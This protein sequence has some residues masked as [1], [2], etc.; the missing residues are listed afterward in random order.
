MADA[1]GP[2]DLQAIR[3]AMR[4]KLTLALDGTDIDLETDVAWQNRKFVKPESRS[5]LWAE[6]ILETIDE[7]Q[8]SWSMAQWLGYYTWSFK[9]GAGLGTGVL[10]SAAK[11]YR[12]VYQ[13]GSLIQNAGLTIH[14]EKVEPLLVQPESNADNAWV[15]LP[16]RS[17]L[18]VVQ[19]IE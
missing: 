9:I 8:I 19:S 16:V 5:K 14:I 3:V 15:E 6:E 13:L 2:I 12:E 10:E 11:K 4:T 1:T 17:M 7:S 18:R